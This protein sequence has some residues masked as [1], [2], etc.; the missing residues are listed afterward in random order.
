VSGQRPSAPCA[1][2]GAW[3]DDV[4]FVKS[5]LGRLQDRVSGLRHIPPPFGVMEG[6]ALVWDRDG[7]HE[8]KRLGT[9]ADWADAKWPA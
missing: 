5:V 9:L 1:Q 3:R 8:E 6:H 2:A 7:R 4:I